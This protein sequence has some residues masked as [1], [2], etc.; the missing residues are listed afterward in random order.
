MKKLLFFIFIILSLFLPSVLAGTMTRTLS[1][2]VVAPNEVFQL[3]YDS[4]TR[5]PSYW[6]FDEGMPIGFT[7]T[8]KS[9]YYVCSDNWGDSKYQLT[10]RIRSQS[11]ALPYSVSIKAS[12]VP[13]VYKFS[14]GNT[15]LWIDQNDNPL[16][17]LQHGESLQIT[18]QSA[19]TVP[20]STESKS[21]DSSSMVLIIGGG[22]M[23]FMMMFAMS[24]RKRG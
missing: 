1:K 14:E 13:G 12:S 16:G 23:L 15:A 7:P 6:T 22:V 4:P 21:G 2:S 19:G 3:I 10:C 8:D 9:L 5:T 17:T 18:V 24:G 11:G 20:P